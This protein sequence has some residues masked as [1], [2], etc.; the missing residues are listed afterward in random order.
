MFQDTLPNS[1]LQLQA[2]TVAWAH[3]Q[4]DIRA[5]LLI[6]SLARVEHPADQWSDLDLLLLTSDNTP[7][8]DPDAAWLSALGDVLVV[9]VE[10]ANPGDPDVQAVFSDGGKGDFSF[11]T[12]QNPERPLADLLTELTYQD[13]LQRGAFILFDRY[14][15]PRTYV[16][17]APPPAPTPLTAAEYKQLIN[18]FWLYTHRVAKFTQRGD[19][20]RAIMNL[21]FR[22]NANLLTLMEWHAQIKGRDTWY[23][24]RFMD[25]WAE[26]RA[27]ELL[28][29]TFAH[30]N[31]DDLRRALF[32]AIALF[33]LL[34]TEIAQHLG[35]PYLAK[36]D[37]T[38]T[39]MIE[40]IF[41]DSARDH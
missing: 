2:R 32:A 40:T 35:Y 27:L 25:D 20:W 34:A 11:I 33:R 6:G 12:V 17:S 4:P 10:E 3:T 5:V 39:A 41:A 36:Q 30:Y 22:V 14:G 8:A 7:Y 19:L 31:A 1:L 9:A 16:P 13:V 28:P 23:D 26:P 18:H 24:G 38:I 29:Q 37:A 21:N 15:E